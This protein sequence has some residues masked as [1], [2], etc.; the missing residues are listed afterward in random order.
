M[1]SKLT[2]DISGKLQLNYVRRMRVEKTKALQALLEA[3]SVQAHHEVGD[4]EGS[5]FDGLRRDDLRARARSLGVTLRAGSK[6]RT[7]AELRRACVE[8]TKALQ[9]P[10]NVEGH[11]TLDAYFRRPQVAQAPEGNH[12]RLADGR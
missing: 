5:K 8:K 2:L 10:P 12:A 6:W 3:E 1:E 4:G 7:T 11:G 9:T